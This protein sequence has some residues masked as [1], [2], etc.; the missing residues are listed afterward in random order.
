L[1]KVAFV[2]LAP[3]ISGSERC[4]QVIL[5]NCK[6]NDVDPILIS[7]ANSPMHEWASLHSIK[8]YKIDLQV[9]NSRRPWRWLIAQFK[10]F[11]ILAV[12][13]IQ[14]AHSNQIWSYRVITIPT[15]L[16]GI[17]RI[18]H[19][20]D[21]LHK[22]SIWWLNSTVDATIC[23]SDHIK[24]QYDEQ[25]SSRQSH[26]VKTIIDPV[27]FHPPM[28]STELIAAKETA[29]QKLGLDRN[30]FIFGFIGQIAP[31][32]GL[33][34]LLNCLSKL[35]HKNWL[36]VVAGKDPS[37]SQAYLKQCIEL[38]KQLDITDRVKFIGFVENSKNFYLAVDLIA[39][40]S[41]QEPLG[42]IPLEAAVNYT[43]T[44]ANKVGGLPETIQDGKTG[45]LVDINDHKN[46]QKT[47][48][49]ILSTNLTDVGLQARKWVEL[50]A[51]P[52][53]YSKTL[54]DLYHEIL[55]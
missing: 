18:C 29:K 35:E 46:T 55:R 28:S 34:E 25:F 42:L 13:R 54:V 33:V 32:K 14:I 5:D 27:T 53:N 47:I 15:S 23:I 45:W 30:T 4:L 50:V 9:F 48:N 22:G 7:P 31:V 43:P 10:V 44:I 3:F 49:L 16:L 8:S 24:R 36:L 20:R 6:H 21:P 38:A 2:A 1:L 17:K 11:Y 19:M 40:F 41:L 12:R 39:M 26:L 51:E 37:E 52:S